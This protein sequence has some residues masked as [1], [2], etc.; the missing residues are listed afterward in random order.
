M[1]LS[2][3]SED[4]GGEFECPQC[5]KTQTVPDAHRKSA[6]QT[7]E[8]IRS[9]APMAVPSPGV[10][11]ARTPTPK[12]KIVISSHLAD[13]EYEPESMGG[14]GVAL[15]SAILGIAGFLLCG[16]A[17]TWMI[18]SKEWEQPALWPVAM[19]V[20][21]MSFFMGLMG[22]VIAQL[23]RFVVT[24]ADRVSRKEKES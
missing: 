9:M 5:Q 7:A 20:L 11:A 16:L 8:G 14:T 19:I 1:K 21:L 6:D 2:A 15:F 10:S 12:R 18:L 3:E 17:T 13:T 24:L 22:L 23:S 4:V